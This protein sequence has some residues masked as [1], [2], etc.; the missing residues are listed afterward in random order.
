MVPTLFF[1]LLHLLAAAVVVEGQK[2]AQTQ[3]ERLGGRAAVQADNLAP[4]LAVAEH[5]DKVI[6]AAGTPLK[7]L[8]L[9]VQAAAALALKV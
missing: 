7:L 6:M 4:I 5:Q 2:L 1:P 3:T 9:L 8:V